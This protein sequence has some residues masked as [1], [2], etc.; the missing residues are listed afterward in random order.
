MVGRQEAVELLQE[1]GVEVRRGT[2]EPPSL[3][4]DTLGQIAAQAPRCPSLW[5]RGDVLRQPAV[6][7]GRAFR[8]GEALEAKPNPREE[9]EKS[10]WMPDR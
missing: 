4:F 5:G 9:K 8:C 1:L 7:R 10:S 2:C 6:P 3:Y